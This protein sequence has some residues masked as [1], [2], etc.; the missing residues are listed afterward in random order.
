MGLGRFPEVGGASSWRCS[1]T[2]STSSIRT[3]GGAS[4]GTGTRPIPMPLDVTTSFQISI[5]IN[6][7]RGRSGFA[8][9]S[10]RWQATTSTVPA[11][12]CGGGEGRDARGLPT[13]VDLAGEGLRCRRSRRRRRVADAIRDSATRAAVLSCSWSGGRSPDVEAALEDIG[14]LGRNGLGSPLF[15][16]TGNGH[17]RP[18]AYPA[19]DPNSIAVG[20]ST[21]QATIASYSTSAPRSRL[22]HR[23]AAGSRGCTRPMSASPPVASRPLTA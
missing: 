14:V 13:W 2:A 18:V 10:I 8:F 4:G 19:S 1:T 7:T 9:R 17:G 23:R 11:C 20:A 5:P 3:S 16:A 12:R 15:A 22:S 21:D 6:S